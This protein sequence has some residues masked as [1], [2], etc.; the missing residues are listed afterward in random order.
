MGSCQQLFQLTF[1]QSW[2]R[3]RANIDDWAMEWNGSETH[4]K[5]IQEWIIQAGACRISHPA[6]HS[7]FSATHTQQE[8][9]SEPNCWSRYLWLDIY[10]MQLGFCFVCSPKAG[11]GMTGFRRSRRLGNSPHFSLLLCS[12]AGVD[13]PHTHRRTAGIKWTTWWA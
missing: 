1:V 4:A 6:V 9:G 12:T 8:D 11:R 3:R 5:I 13:P 7:P 10:Y 2:G